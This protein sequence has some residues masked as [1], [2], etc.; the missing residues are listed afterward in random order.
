M[1]EWDI[2]VFTQ[3]NQEM[4]SQFLDA[5][6][7][8]IRDGSFWLPLYLILF[9]LA[10]IRYKWKAFIWLIFVF[11]TVGISDGIT[12]YALKKQ[13]ERHRPCHSDSPVDA[14][15][16]VK[17]GSGYSMSSAH[18]SNH[19]SMAVIFAFS[20]FYGHSLAVFLLLFWAISI[21]Y[22]QI[23]VGVHFP[24]DILVGFIVGALAGNL[25]L[26]L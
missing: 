9:I 20:L 17:C 1:I 11:L 5:V 26:F 14:R 4:T 19:M 24:S 6:L 13:I 22:A 15:L 8:P 12:N 10:L 23:Y 7:P 16:L 21:G 2:M 25:G 18:A 3:I